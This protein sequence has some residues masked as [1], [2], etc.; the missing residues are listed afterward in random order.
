MRGAGTVTLTIAN[1]DAML[2]SD[3]P[4]QTAKLTMINSTC[5]NPKALWL[6][7]MNSVTWPDDTQLAQL[8]TASA[9]CEEQLP[10]VSKE[11]HAT[12]TITL[13]AYAAAMLTIA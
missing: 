3:A 7:Q 11:G 13:E 8:R 12:V 1:A 2:P 9:M 4:E 6:E 10:I 5:A